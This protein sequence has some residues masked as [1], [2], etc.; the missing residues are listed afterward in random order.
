MDATAA[1]LQSQFKAAAALPA[2]IAAAPAV[3]VAAAF[4]HCCAGKG[5]DG[6]VTKSKEQNM[7][8]MVRTNLRH[9]FSKTAILFFF[10]FNSVVFAGVQ[11]DQQGGMHG[12]Q[13][14][15]PPGFG[16]PKNMDTY[17]KSFST[18]LSPPITRSPSP[19][20]FSIPPLPAPLAARMIITGISWATHICCRH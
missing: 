1:G 7:A 5:P 12:M 9:F 4:F 10:C 17:S 19:S 6:A 3:F 13:L 20:L 15:N 2:V 11:L 8:D 18:S 16:I 14:V